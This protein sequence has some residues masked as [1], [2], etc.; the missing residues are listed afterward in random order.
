MPV[1]TPIALAPTLLLTLALLAG[2]SV[3]Q[4][5]DGE[6]AVD[7]MSVISKAGCNSGTC[8][9]NLNGKGGFKLSLRGQDARLDYEALVLHSRGRRVN[10]SSPDESLVLLKATAQVPHRGGR[11]FEVGS[12]EYKVLRNWIAGGTAKPA[13]HAPQVDRLEVSP[14]KAI[15]TDPV[16]ELQL[17]VT[18][19]F[20]DGNSRDVT[21][22]ACYELSNLIATVDSAGKVTRSELGETTLIVRY[23]QQQVPVSIAFTAARPDFAWSDPPVN[24]LV[25]RLV[26]EKLQSLKMNPSELSD[27]YVFVRRAYLDATGR[28]PSGD[29]ARRFVTDQSPDKRTRLID[30]LLSMPEFADFWA[31]KWADVLRTEEK[32][33]DVEGVEAFHSWIRQSIAT[34]QPLDE[35][36]R[37]LVTGTG[38]TFKNPPANYYRANRD[39]STRGET[40]ARLF[41]GTRLQCAKC[42]NH[43]F[44]R[45]TQ[46]D[47]YEWSSLFSQIDYE[48]G[49]NKR[50]D[51]LDKNEFV[52]EQVVLVA[53]QDE[54]RNPTTGE[55]ARPKFL[56]G[57]ALSDAAAQDRL[58]AVATWLTS[59][60]ND[61]FAKSQVNFIWYHLMGQGLVDPIDDFRLTNPASNP[62]LLEALASR[63]VAEEFD[64]RSLV[65]LIM[66]SRTYQLS[67]EPNATNIND[68]SSYSHALIRRLPAEVLLD[69]QSDVL[70]VP[71]EFVGYRIGIRAVQI[72][73]VQR[74]RPRDESPRPGDR[75]L[76]TFGKPDRILACECERSNETTLKQVFALIGEGLSARLAVN[77]NRVNRLALSESRSE[78]L[79]ES[80]YWE[81]LS[82]PPTSEELEAAVA[83][84]NSSLD[85]RSLAL[86]DIAWALLNAKE[87]LFRR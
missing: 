72:P 64:V 56:G 76:K 86:Q 69:A 47:Y 35:F 68:R 79:V 23:L 13:P 84:L 49:E 25:D 14:D 26:F 40:T 38:S 10:P 65:R 9:G 32:V 50:K 39:A 15:L 80:L 87:F 71:A 28:I 83:M 5:A 20:S 61:R 70:D 46:D 2:G 54:V 3:A 33:L 6:F 66:T 36:V 30:Q 77:G 85:G 62:E 82:R 24:N 12:P 55:I 34:A 16:D 27:D 21:T 4:S 41:L 31:L 11:R 74:K 75:F 53:K 81:T 57:E 58:A 52:G 44:D 7:V 43:P 8:H 42:H 59:E 51:T 63:F 1:R 17:H 22:R 18:A 73:G 78:H 19:H 48:I 60:E 45:W 67:A 29:E 37:A